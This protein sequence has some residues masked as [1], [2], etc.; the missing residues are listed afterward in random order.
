MEAEE[1]SQACLRKYE[2]AFHPGGRRSGQE[3]NN[4]PATRGKQQKTAIE[5]KNKASQPL[6]SNS[7]VAGLTGVIGLTKSINAS[8]NN[9]AMWTK[10]TQRTSKEVTTPFNASEVKRES[11]KLPNAK[12]IARNPRR[13]AMSR[14]EGSRPPSVARPRLPAFNKKNHLRKV[15]TKTNLIHF[16]CYQLNTTRC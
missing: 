12:Q 10:Q 8:T 9:P 16:E 2:E 4:S 14:D 15:A 1:T 3:V 7:I 6:P 5:N 11:M 13:K